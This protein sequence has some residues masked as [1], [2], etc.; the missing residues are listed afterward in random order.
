MSYVTKAD[1]KIPLFSQSE[2]NSLVFLVLSS[3]D[4]FLH[5][6]TPAFSIIFFISQS[7]IKYNTKGSLTHIQNVQQT[8][9][10]SYIHQLKA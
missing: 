5:V 8:P 4:N 6:V 10:N 2:S 3:S 9:F 7:C 1:H